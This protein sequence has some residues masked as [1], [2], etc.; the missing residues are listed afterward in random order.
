ML[1]SRRPNVDKALV[2]PKI[3]IGLGTVV[4]DE[5]FAMLIGAHRARIDIDVAGR[6]G[7][8]DPILRSNCLR[9]LHTTD[10]TEG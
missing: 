7:P 1:S 6:A 5:D 8:P 4:G 9:S 2:V 3:E 10:Q